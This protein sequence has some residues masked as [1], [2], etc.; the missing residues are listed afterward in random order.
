MTSSKIRVMAL[1]LAG[2]LLASDLA[3]AAPP[4]MLFQGKPI[5]DLGAA[6]G[7]RTSYSIMRLP[8]GGFAFYN[9]NNPQSGPLTLPDGDGV[10]H[11]LLPCLPPEIANSKAI[12][13]IFK[14]R[15]Y[16][17]VR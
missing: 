9:R 15:A 5:A 6:G 12:A 13:E 14:P 1:L 2:T 11:T 10:Q 3:P 7:T 8:N 4:K 17:R 16:E